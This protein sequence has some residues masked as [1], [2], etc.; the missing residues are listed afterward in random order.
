MFFIWLCLSY[1][2]LFD[3]FDIACSAL[4]VLLQA[5]ADPSSHSAPSPAIGPEKKVAAT[6]GNIYALY[7]VS[8]HLPTY[9]SYD[10]P[11]HY[12]L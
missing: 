4:F 11:Y 1:I 6:E 5:K 9:I 3:I 12:I 8:C 2:N 7:Y 10:V